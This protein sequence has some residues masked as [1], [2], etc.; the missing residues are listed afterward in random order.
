MNGVLGGHRQRERLRVGVADVLRREPHETPRDIKGIFAGLPNPFV[1]TRYHSLA[2]RTETLSSDFE[3]SAWTADKECMA[4]RHKT[5]RLE[6][7][8]FHPESFMTIEG[9]KLLANFLRK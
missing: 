4:I 3:I 7:V 5:A 1:A 6:G 9:S 2:I 8:Q